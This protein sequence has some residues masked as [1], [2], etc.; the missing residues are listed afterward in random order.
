MLWEV[1][2][3]NAEFYGDFIGPCEPNL[4]AKVF[5]RFYRGQRLLDACSAGIEVHQEKLQARLTH[6]TRRPHGGDFNLEL[7][8]AMVASY[9]KKLIEGQKILDCLFGVG[10][11]RVLL[12]R[13]GGTL[14]LRSKELVRRMKQGYLAGLSEPAFKAVTQVFGIRRFYKNKREV[15]DSDRKISAFVK[16]IL[17]KAF[18]IEMESS[19]DGFSNKKNTDSYHD[20]L[21]TFHAPQCQALIYRWKAKCFIP[22]SLQDL[23]GDCF[24]DE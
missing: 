16:S 9:A 12:D 17:D 14:S 18:E 1:P 5:E 20:A 24:F 4:I 2:G 22:S 3:V 19:E 15:L 7:F 13:E 6:M 10:G 8:R 11:Y 23:V 21:K